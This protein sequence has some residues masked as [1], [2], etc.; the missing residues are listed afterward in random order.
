MLDIS[1]KLV[2]PC[3]VCCAAGSC[4]CQAGHKT[5]QSSVG[6]LAS[7]RCR[8]SF[9]FGSSALQFGTFS[10][11]QSAAVVTNPD[12]AIV[13]CSSFS[14]FCSKAWLSCTVF[15]ASQQGVAIYAQPDHLV[16]VCIFNSQ[17]SSGC[18][19]FCQL[20]LHC[21]TLCFVCFGSM[22]SIAEFVKGVAFAKKD[23][24]WDEEVV[25]IFL[26]NECEV[27]CCFSL[28]IS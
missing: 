25:E 23:E 26:R 12:L 4:S 9:L 18:E 11:Q 19:A 14:H 2:V 22:S 13:W 24:K 8:L 15:F 27:V 10:S 16:F 20:S 1:S 6:R 3:G 7:G 5:K 21:V 28:R 17:V